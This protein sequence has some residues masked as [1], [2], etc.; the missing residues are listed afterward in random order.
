MMNI[1]WSK[2]LSAFCI[3]VIWIVNGFTQNATG[4]SPEILSDLK[5]S[6]RMDAQTR[7]VMNA[8]TSNDLNDLVVNRS[9]INKYNDIFN[10]M[11]DVKG[12]TNQNKSGRCWMYAALNLLRPV[13][14]EKFNLESFEFSQSYLFFWDKLEKYNFF[15]ESVIAMRDRDIMD[16][17]LQTLLDDP[18]GDGGWWNYITALIEKYGVVPK[19]IM[20]E[21]KNSENSRWLNKNLEFLA[22]QNASQLRHMAAEGKKENEL[23]RQKTDML[24]KVYRLLVIYLGMPPAEFTWHYQDKNKTVHE[25]S[26]TPVQ[27]YHDAV[28]LDLNDYVIFFNYPAHPF[29][30][31][32]QVDL[33]RNLA[34]KSNLTFINLDIDKIKGYVLNSLLNKEPVWFAADAGWQMERTHGIMA[35]DIY[36]YESLLGLSDQM[37]KADRIQYRASSANHAMAFVGVDT[38][39]GKAMKWRVENSWGA[40]TGDHGYWTMYNDWFDTYVYTVVIN[41]KY[42]PEQVLSILKTKPRSL[43]TW[44]P[45]ARPF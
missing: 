11:A 14:R 8:V 13:A 9:I 26:Y 6:I 38:L 33:R 2:R 42:V 35:D 29:N 43:P 34:D 5:N 44:D 22:R 25:N 28:G 37:S 41:K 3:L 31:L 32:Y 21:T 20:P 1:P 4:L 12:I 16:R 39:N 7:A 10:V 45:L 27:F 24:K 18:L 40:D 30:T 17:D 15:L 19:E 36:D 23:R